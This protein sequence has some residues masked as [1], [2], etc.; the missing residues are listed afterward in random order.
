M[1]SHCAI[2]ADN[3][4]TNF[5]RTSVDQVL[6]NLRQA[7]RVLELVPPTQTELTP[8]PLIIVRAEIENARR[9][10]A[11]VKIIE[12]ESETQILRNVA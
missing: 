12:Y 11:N 4:L 6:E 7:L 10:L 3:A 8:H 2:V 5:N 9:Y 1:S